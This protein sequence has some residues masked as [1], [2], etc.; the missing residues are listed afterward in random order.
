[1]GDKTFGETN[2]E[3]DVSET[4]FFRNFSNG[5]G[6]ADSVKKSLFNVSKMDFS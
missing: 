5:V 3:N 1:M 4:F 2:S 6:V